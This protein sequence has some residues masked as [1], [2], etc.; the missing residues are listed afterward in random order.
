MHVLQK[1][2]NL[3]KKK[4]TKKEYSRTVLF[5]GGIK[6]LSAN[7]VRLHTSLIVHHG[8]DSIQHS[9]STVHRQSDLRP[10]EI[11]LIILYLH[12]IPKGIQT[13]T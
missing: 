3:I 10:V 1:S 9:T 12:Q 4:N 8:I 5:S 6:S 13:L 2:K 7:T 11:H